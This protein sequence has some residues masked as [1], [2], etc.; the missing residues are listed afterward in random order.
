ML[1]DQYI[2]CSP[3]S[4]ILDPFTLLHFLLLSLMMQKAKCVSNM[5][6]LIGVLSVS[7]T[8]FPR[9]GYVLFIDRILASVTVYRMK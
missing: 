2:K 9:T 1:G 8:K 3:S 4:I 6:L 7:S 5:Y